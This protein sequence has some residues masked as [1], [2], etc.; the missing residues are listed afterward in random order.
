MSEAAQYGEAKSK[1]VI[2]K[3]MGKYP[4]L[5]SSA[6]DLMDI[7]DDVITK[8][9]SMS[10]EDLQ[11]YIPVKKP[12][13]EKVVER[14]LPPLNNPDS[15]VLRFAPGPSGPIHLGHTRALALNNYYKN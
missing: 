12:K 8:V 1:S 9:N 2:G 10:P 13:T 4:E 3:A 11:P 14:E 15:M 7:I 5:R 6:K